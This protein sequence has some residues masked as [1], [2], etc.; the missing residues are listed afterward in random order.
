MQYDIAFTN[1]YRE[2]MRADQ[3][4]VEWG[5]RGRIAEPAIGPRIKL[6]LQRIAPW[7]DPGAVDG[8]PAP[9]MMRVG[10]SWDAN[11]VLDAGGGTAQPSGLRMGAAGA[12]ARAVGD[13]LKRAAR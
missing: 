9:V 4:I 10:A 11:L 6:V 7:I 1:L 3:V 13:D 2:G 5:E 12:P 8:L